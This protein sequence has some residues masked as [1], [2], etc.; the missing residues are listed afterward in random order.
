MQAKQGLILDSK[1]L[2]MRKARE[3]SFQTQFMLLTCAERVPR[4]LKMGPGKNLPGTSDSAG[5]LG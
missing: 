2:N 5:K 1:D 4:S 3:A